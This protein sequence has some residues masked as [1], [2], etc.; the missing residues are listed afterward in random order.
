MN[1]FK[2]KIICKWSWFKYRIHSKIYKT[3]ERPITD[4]GY[5]LQHWFIEQNRDKLDELKKS[6]VFEER[7][8]GDKTEKLM[9]WVSDEYRK[10]YNENIVNA[11][12]KL[13]K[14]THIEK[15]KYKK[16]KYLIIYGDRLGLIIGEKGKLIDFLKKDM[17]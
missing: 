13:I 4:L 5:S 7:Q 3:N 14:D 2:Q 17:M 10:F 15:Y 16:G 11:S 9:S 8:F 1:K 12:I 6:C